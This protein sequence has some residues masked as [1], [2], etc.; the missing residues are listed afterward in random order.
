MSQ[1]TPTRPRAP[2]TPLKA[3]NGAFGIETPSGGFIYNPFHKEFVSQLGHAVFSP[4]LF[5]IG[6]SPEENSRI[7]SNSRSF[8]SPEDVSYL[9][10]AEIDENP[11]LQM[12]L[13]EKLD[14]QFHDEKI[15]KTIETYFHSNL[16][17]P[18]P[19][20]HSNTNR[21]PFRISSRLPNL[22]PKRIKKLPQS[23]LSKDSSIMVADVG[24]QTAI[25]IP[26]EFDLE[27]LLASSMAKSTNIK[28]EAQSSMLVDDTSNSGFMGLSS[29]LPPEDFSSGVDIGNNSV[30][31]DACSVI[32]RDGAYPNSFLC[33][34]CRDSRIFNQQNVK[35]KLFSGEQLQTEE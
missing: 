13:Q 26:F 35:R 21:L 28:P 3:K 24:A 31:L 22:T 7:G 8:F 27:A 9:T 29:V 33:S 5:A 20:T 19:D 17:V 10:H 30:L 16:I 1:N 34:T 32:R 12:K 15:Q 23:S 2:C 18:S 6:K 4:G 11:V 14:S 25:S